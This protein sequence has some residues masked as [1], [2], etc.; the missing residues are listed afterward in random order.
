MKRHG[1]FPFPFTLIIKIQH[2]D[3]YYGAANKVQRT[4]SPFAMFSAS[5]WKSSGPP[6][7][8][9]ATLNVQSHISARLVHQKIVTNP[10]MPIQRSSVCCA[11]PRLMYY[12]IRFVDLFEILLIRVGIDSTAILSLASSQP[13][14]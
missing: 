12:L 11:Q 1:P 5:V 2:T 8:H 7:F 9:L 3:S 10:T 14:E 4:I 13:R 6:F